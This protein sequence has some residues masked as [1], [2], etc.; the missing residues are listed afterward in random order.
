LNVLLDTH[1]WI[2]H[3]LGNVEL[4][5]KKRAILENPETG[6]WLSPI[7]VWE[8]LVLAEKGKLRLEPDALRWVR[9]AQ[10][11]FPVLEASLNTEIAI[12]SREI[13]LEYQDPADRFLAATALVFDLR[14]MTE[15]RRLSRVKWLPTV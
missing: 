5:Q 10:S 6:I 11:R 4:S 13:T 12:K 15:D 1:I 9:D 3:L 7:S 14:L 8:T 2:W